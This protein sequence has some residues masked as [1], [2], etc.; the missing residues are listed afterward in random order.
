MSLI[1]CLTGSIVFGGA[2]SVVQTRIGD[3][4][5]ASFIVRTQTDDIDHFCL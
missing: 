5:H 3:T 4:S 2:S 1:G